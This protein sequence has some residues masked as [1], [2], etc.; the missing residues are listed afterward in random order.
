MIVTCT[1]LMYDPYLQ[2]EL[3]DKTTNALLFY[4]P[5]SEDIVDSFQIGV[6][7]EIVITKVDRPSTIK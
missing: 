1:K 3:V 5:D 2:V 4:W 7:Y 6:D